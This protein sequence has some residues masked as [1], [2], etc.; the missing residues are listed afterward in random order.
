[1]VMRGSVVCPGGVAMPSS[2]E[3][4]SLID[5][6]MEASSKGKP[7]ALVLVFHRSLAESRKAAE[8]AA[9]ALERVL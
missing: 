8:A 5:S 4:D 6:A 1:M 3:L 2:A 7:V 9:A